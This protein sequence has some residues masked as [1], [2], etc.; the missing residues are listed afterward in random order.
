M[1]KHKLDQQSECILAVTPQNA[2]SGSSLK[3]TKT[4][5]LSIRSV[6]SADESLPSS[7]LP[8][9]LIARFPVA[10]TSEV[11]SFLARYHSGSL[12]GRAR[13]LVS[14]RHQFVGTHLGTAL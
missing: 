5:G 6:V 9:Q 11:E 7:M 8:P 4:I 3:K 13:S 10:T 12:Q 2:E 1:H 14:S